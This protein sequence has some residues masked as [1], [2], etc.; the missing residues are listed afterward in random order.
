MEQNIMRSEHKTLHKNKQEVF[1]YWENIS[2]RM[3]NNGTFEILKEKKIFDHTWFITADALITKGEIQ[4]GNSILDAGC[5]WG[6]NISGI[7]F[8]IPETKIVGIDTD[9]LRLERGQIFLEELKL[10]DNTE[11]KIGDVDNLDFNDNEFDVVVSARV[12]QYVPDPMTTINELCRVL[13][14]GG[15]L[16]ITVPNKFNP[17][18]LATYSRVLYSPKEVK[19]WFIENN[20]LDISCNTIGFIPTFKRYHWQSKILLIENVKYIPGINLL[21]GLVVCSGTKT[22][23]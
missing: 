12:L 9:Q 3:E 2:Q 11:L 23:S 10:N 7:K 14:P 15:K 16:V 1:R 4:P 6:R 17:Y 18:R 21:G 19:S 5:G 8:F 13:K 22:D 20:L